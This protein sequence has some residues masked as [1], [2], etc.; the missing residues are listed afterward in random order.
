LLK[1]RHRPLGLLGKTLV[2]RVRS[3]DLW[4]L[5]DRAP[6]ARQALNGADK[7]VQHKGSQQSQIPNRMEDVK[8]PKGAH[9][10]AG[11]PVAQGCG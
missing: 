8:E 10:S 3:D 2:K 7:G 1:R 9:Q 5:R 6:K 11:M 4:R